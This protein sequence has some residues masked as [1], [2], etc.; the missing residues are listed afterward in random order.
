MF[1]KLFFKDVVKIALHK[2][3][4]VRG[5]TWISFALNLHN[6]YVTIHVQFIDTMGY[7]E[8]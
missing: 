2:T 3:Q 6:R 7:F 5:V 8:D 1:A 4:Q